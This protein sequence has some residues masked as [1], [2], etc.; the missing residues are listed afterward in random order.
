MKTW[1]EGVFSLEFSRVEAAN[2]TLRSGAGAGPPVL[3]GRGARGRTA[4]GIMASAVSSQHNCQTAL[5]GY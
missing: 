2:R 3:Q 4:K 5:S 1:E